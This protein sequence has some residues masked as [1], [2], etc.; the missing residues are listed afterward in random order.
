MVQNNLF[1]VKDKVV[2]VTGAARGN[3]RAIAEGFFHHGAIVYFVDRL[4]ELE[5]DISSY[6]KERTRSIICDLGDEEAI[7]AIVTESIERDGRIDVLINNA[8]ISLASEDPYDNDVWE[9][10][11]KIN[12]KA[13]FLLSK[14]VSK[15]MIQQESGAII[16]ITSLGAMLGFPNN[17]SYIASK[18]ALKQLTK[19]MARDLAQYNIRVNNVCP[20]YILT[21]MTRKSYNDPVLKRERD[22]HI[23]LERW[24]SPSDLVGPCIFLASNAANYITG[25]DLPVDGGWLA[26]GL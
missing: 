1:S 11:L 4:K 21:N 18:G 23:I 24:G 19:A 15:I 26:K 20:G 10:T 9:Q 2:I 14:Y 8:G 17:P 7:K 16:N 25:I 13:A 6:G 5:D 3:G 12:L 22:N